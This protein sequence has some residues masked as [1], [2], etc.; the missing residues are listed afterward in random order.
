MA[1]ESYTLAQL[2]TQLTNVQAK[3]DKALNA[4]E[5][6]IG[7]RNLR[8]PSLDALQKREM[9]LSLEISRR[10]DTTGGIGVVEFG[11]PS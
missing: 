5:Y 8:R 2:E 10:Q 4:E 11:E 1:F 3:I 7:S 9:A 6:G